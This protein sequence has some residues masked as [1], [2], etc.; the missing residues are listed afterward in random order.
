MDFPFFFEIQIFVF[1]SWHY[2]V[3]LWKLADIGIVVQMSKCSLGSCK[4]GDPITLAHSGKLEIVIEGH[5]DT[6]FIRL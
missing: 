1:R 4:L 6:R 2:I 5:G 3:T